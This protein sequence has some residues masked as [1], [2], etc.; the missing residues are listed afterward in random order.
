MSIEPHT[1]TNEY[2]YLE[3]IVKEIQQEIECNFKIYHTHAHA[4]LKQLLNN[5][6]IKLT[7]LPIFR[8]R[9]R[10]KLRGR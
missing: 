3:G 10:H 2:L 9:I 5:Q 7:N 6:E 8:K 1:T 4:H